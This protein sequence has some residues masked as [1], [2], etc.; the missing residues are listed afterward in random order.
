MRGERKGWLLLICRRK[1]LARANQ[2]HI[3][4]DISHPIIPLVTSAETS[5][6]ADRSTSESGSKAL[7]S[8]DRTRTSSGI[9]TVSPTGEQERDGSSPPISLQHLVLGFAPIGTLLP[10]ARPSPSRLPWIRCFTISATPPANFCALRGSPSPPS[11]RSRSVSVRPDR[12]STRLN[13]SHR[14]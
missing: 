12:K 7:A 11:A 5:A 9:G 4:H 1:D 2:K 10:L 14:T 8:G 13:S 6:H 3:S